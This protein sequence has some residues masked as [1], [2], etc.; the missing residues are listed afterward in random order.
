MDESDY[1]CLASVV[2]RVDTVG[3]GSVGE[4]P[5]SGSV[6]EGYYREGRGSSAK[7]A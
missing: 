3:E 1:G 7:R 4:G 6:R 2:H 5:F